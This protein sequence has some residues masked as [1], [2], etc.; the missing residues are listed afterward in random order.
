MKGNGQPRSARAQASKAEAKAP[1]AGGKALEAAAKAPEA[2]GER[3][4]ELA[5]EESSAKERGPVGEGGGG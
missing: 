1:E 5:Q 2:E 4:R 3:K